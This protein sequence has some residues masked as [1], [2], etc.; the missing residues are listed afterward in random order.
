MTVVINLGLVCHFSGVTSV[1]KNIHNCCYILYF[2]YGT[3]FCRR[4]NNRI[5]WRK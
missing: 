4:R 2:V 5:T 3:S 1:D